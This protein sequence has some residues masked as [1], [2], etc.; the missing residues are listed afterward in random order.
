[1]NKKNG[2]GGFPSQVVPVYE[3]NSL[4]YGLKVANAVESEWFS[5]DTNSGNNGSRYFSRQ[6]EFHKRRLYARGEQSVQKYKDELS[7]NGDLSYMNLDWK[8]VPIIPKFV[9]IMVNGISQP[10]HQVKAYSQDPSSIAARQEFVESALGDMYSKEYNALTKSLLGM[11]TRRSPLSKQGTLP[12]TKEELEVYMQLDYKQQ[13]EIAQEQL[14]N[15]VADKNNYQK[16]NKRIIEDLTVDGLAGTKTDFNRAEGTTVRRV[17]PANLIYSYTE[18]PHFGDLF[19]VGEVVDVP[20]TELKKY[21]PNISDEEMQELE[22]LAGRQVRE[23]KS[24]TV[25][26][27]HTVEVLFFEWKTYI[28]QVWKIKTTDKGLEKAIVK[29][30]TFNPEPNENFR[31][32]SRTIEVFYEGAKVVGFPK[33]LEWKMA[34]NM[35]RPYGDTVRAKSSYT[36]CAPKMYKGAIESIVS[37]ITSFADMIQLTHLKL[38]QV[39]SRMVPDGI[40]IDADGLAE[41]DLGNGTNYNPAEAINMYFQT[42]SI[43]GRSLTQDGDANRGKIPIQPTTGGSGRDKIQALMETYQSYLQ[44]IRDVTGLNEARDASTP[45][46]DA[47]VGLQK[48]AAANS[49]TATRHIKTAGLAIQLGTYECISLSITDSLN[50]PLTRKALV[51]AISPM[52]V[53]SLVSLAESNSTDFGIFL[54]LEPDEEEQAKLEQNI[55]IALQN[56]S[57]EL[58]DSVDIREIRNIKLANKVLKQRRKLKEQK[59]LEKQKQIQEST[60]EANAAAA[61]RA[62]Q[63]DAQKNQVITE[64]KIQLAQMEAQLDE[65]KMQLE[66]SLKEKLMEKEFEFNMQLKGVE[67]DQKKEQEKEKEDRK[68]ERTRIQATQQSKMIEQR[69]GSAPAQNFESAGQDTMSGFGLEQFD[70]K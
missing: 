48:L 51:Q 6:R 31:K 22:K 26:K 19:Y 63:A 50:F 33:M 65:K 70:P 54:E 34:E 25:E 35:T 18:D 69:N 49:N 53:K 36:L 14:I 47:L 24:Q 46:K 28:D 67:V 64:Q 9:D 61:E 43:V 2:A 37:R 3:K 23:N 32:V 42:G 68:D 20:L 21:Y 12:D 39:I 59:D 16:L 57:I 45:D 15:Y 10:T 41:I 38:Q 27:E 29:E 13:V 52:S 1:M 7:V 5:S 56:Q 66:A 62:A 40:Y 8:P 60:A 44:M 30:D 4:D 11:D 55:Q 58:E 17:D